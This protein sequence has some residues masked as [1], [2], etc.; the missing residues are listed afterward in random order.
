MTPLASRRVAAMLRTGGWSAAGTTIGRGTECTKVDAY[1]V[2]VRWFDSEGSG[3]ARRE[4][5]ADIAGFLRS[6]GCHVVEESLVSEALVVSY[7]L[8]GGAA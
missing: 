4:V 2:R 3:L 7:D 6:C 8:P 1:R 5:L